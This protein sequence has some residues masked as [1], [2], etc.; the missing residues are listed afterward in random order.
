MQNP[1]TLVYALSPRAQA[2]RYVSIAI[3]GLIHA[4]FL[5][6][7]VTGL[8]PK[9]AQKMQHEFSARII[10]TE[11]E[12]PKE[13]VKLPPPQ[14]EKPKVD[15]AVE[16]KIEINQS[17]SSPI[18]VAKAN[19]QSNPDT[20]ATA[21]GSTHSTPPYPPDARR[22]SQQGRVIL[23]IMISPE[24]KVVSAEVAKSS[25][26]PELDKTAQE[27]VVAHWRYKPAMKGGVPVMSETMAA[28]RFDLK[29]G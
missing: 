24:G 15:T 19:P 22:L 28:V 21:V 2:R 16:P 12:K 20:G 23:K 1:R 9:V 17:A 5:Y 10:Q 18:T 14:L 4:V 26:Y 25:G 27:W 7:L 13:T 11:T 8:V 3:V 6:G 29:S